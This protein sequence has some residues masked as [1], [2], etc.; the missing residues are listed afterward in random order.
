MTV[1]KPGYAKQKTDNQ[2]QRFVGRPKALGI[3]QTSVGRRVGAEYRCRNSHGVFAGT[4]QR[5]L[6]DLQR[7]I[8][9]HAAQHRLWRIESH[10]HPVSKRR[11]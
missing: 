5:N 8:R 3:A 10:L 9:M 6:H 7:R 2:Q 4:G 1:H 11:E